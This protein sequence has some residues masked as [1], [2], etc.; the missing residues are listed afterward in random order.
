MVGAESG[1]SR[2]CKGTAGWVWASRADLGA[3]HGVGGRLRPAARKAALPRGN[4][5]AWQR[6][7]GG[8]LRQPKNPPQRALLLYRH[9]LTVHVP[10]PGSTAGLSMF[11]RSFARPSQRPFNAQSPPP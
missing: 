8:A 5:T 10:R 2:R 11:H 7:D 9:T 6:R 3:Y 4:R 1:R